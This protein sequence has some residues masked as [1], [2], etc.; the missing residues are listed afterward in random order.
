MKN[1]ITIASILLIAHGAFVIVPALL[2]F[3]VFGAMQEYMQG[4]PAFALQIGTAFVAIFALFGVIS[5]V[6]GIG[7]LSRKSWARTLGIV[8]AVLTLFNF[9]IGTLIG[10]YALWVLFNEETR[11]EFGAA[12]PETA[13]RI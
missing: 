13:H 1:H 2:F 9:P 6:A 12:A 3:G 11:R 8:A 4:V 5:I 10:G 7:L